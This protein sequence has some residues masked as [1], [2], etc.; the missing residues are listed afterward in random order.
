MSVLVAVAAVLVVL[1]LALEVSAFAALMRA[2]LFRFIFR[3]LLATAMVIVGGVLG[4]VGLGAQGLQVLANEET[5]ARI[6]V[7]PTGPQRYDATVRFADGRSERFALAGDDIYIDAHVVKWTPLA[8][9]LG[10]S[11]SYRLDRI[12]GRYR[13]ITQ[14]T[15]AQRTVYPLSRS[16]WVDLVDVGRRF[17]MAAFF[18]AEYGSA[19]Y[20]PVSR[21]EELELSVSSSGLLLRRVPAAKTGA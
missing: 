17:P 14:E 16:A 12:A 5:A 20:V 10:L 1:G 13:T 15:T 11:T 6:S 18:D 19:T 4:V 8:N 2:R 7:V 9:Q 3:S 21:A